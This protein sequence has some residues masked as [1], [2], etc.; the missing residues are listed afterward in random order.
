MNYCGG[1]CRSGSVVHDGTFYVN[2]HQDSTNRGLIT[3]NTDTNSWDYNVDYY[4]L[5]HI[6]KFVDPGAQRIDSTSLDNNI[7][8]VAFKNPDGSKVLVLANLV[9]VGFLNDIAHKWYVRDFLLLNSCVDSHLLRID[10]TPSQNST[11]RWLP[12]QKQG[13]LAVERI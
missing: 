4:T 9:A 1:S 10:P 13:I 6:S 5:G 12:Y 2:Q 11:S 3:I 8:T 7:E